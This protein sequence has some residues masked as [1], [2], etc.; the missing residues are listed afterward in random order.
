MAASTPTT[1]PSTPTPAASTITNTPGAPTRRRSRGSWTYHSFMIV[2]A[3]LWF[4]PI[5]WMIS[6]AVTPNDVLQQ[7][8]SDLLPRSLTLEN[9]VSVFATGD[10]GRWFLNSAVVTT[11][12]TAVTVI[13]SAMAG[14]AFAK[15]SFP[16]R[17]MLF[18]IVLAGLMVPKEAMFVPLFLMF[19]GAHGQNSYEALILPR[20]A[21]PLG[22]FIM[23]QFFSKV[24]AE[25]EEAARIDG[26]GRWRVFFEIMLPLARPAM[27]SLAIFT[28]V[29]TWNDYLWPLVISTKTEWFTVTTGLASLQSNF[30][31]TTNLGDLMARGLI[32]S[33]PLLIIFL[34]FQRQL[35]RG[36][37]LGSGEK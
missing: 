31:A 36:I 9:L 22:V 17:R 6:M 4:A 7:S 1:S 24:P 21:A 32:G 25:V 15:I 35:I 28:F 18:V 34:A 29:L 14:Y 13:F 11:V 5:L 3:L 10:L 23:T 37:T 19:S 20:L 8:S 2:A 33:L 30:A 26:A 16:G 12:T 27:A